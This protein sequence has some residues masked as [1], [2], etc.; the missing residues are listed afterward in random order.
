MIRTT[1]N[2]MPTLFVGHGS[3]MIAL[4]DNRYTD[5]WRTLGQSMPRPKGILAIS[6][7]WNTRGTAVTAMDAPPTIHDF[8]GFPKALFELQYPAPGDPM[9]AKR[10]SELLAPV[11]VRM[12]HSWGLDHGVWSVLIKVFPQADIPV[13]QLSIDITQPD[14]AHFALGRKLGALRDE[15][16]LVIGT[17]GVVHNLALM[18]RGNAPAYDWA[19]RF[20]DTVRHCLLRNDTEQLVNYSGW[21]R[22]AELSVPTPEHFLP[23]LYVVG[24]RQDNE[25]ISI[26]VDGIEAGSISMLT[27]VV[28]TPN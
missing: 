20:N 19:V 17:G 23:L 5:A 6:A 25:A 10:V 28:G 4:Q 14:S 21:G 24:T 2:R 27:A 9:L 15:G 13:V 16:I 7:H 12:D 18:A 3:P 11:E 22:D 1:Q 8:G 26:P